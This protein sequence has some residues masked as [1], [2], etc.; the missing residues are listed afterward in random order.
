MD[1]EKFTNQARQVFA[2]SQQ[3]LQRYKHNQLDIEHILLAFL[4]QEGGIV[5]RI[6]EEAKVNRR[7]VIG[8]IERELAS[9]P[10]A[11]QPPV[12]DQQQVYITP[13]TQRVL[14][15]A[16]T[17]AERFGDT[18]V[19][20]EHI[21]LAILEDGQ[22]AAARLLVQAGMTEEDALKALQAIRGDHRV[23]DEAAESKYEALAKYSRDLTELA[24]EG[25]LDPVI[26]RDREIRRVIQ[27][28]SRRTKNNP[29][30]IGEAGV[31]KTAI[32]EGLASA[33][34]EGTVPS[35]LEGKRVL[36]LDLGGMI[37]GSKYR[38]EFE[39]RLK[40]VMD[41]IREAQGEIIVF[42][43]ELHTVV[44]A[45]AAEG[46]MDASNM[47]KPALA[48]GE[49][50][51]IGAT[52]LDE[53]RKNIEK[54]PALERR[55]QPIVVDEP[56]VEDTIEILKGLRSRYE[57]HH[58]VKITD[59]ALEAAAKLSE[60]Y[61]PDRNLP[62]KAIDVIDEAGARLRIDIFDLPA[63]P[64]KLREDIAALTEKGAEA[65]QDGRYDEAAETKQK[66]D[67]LQEKLPAAEQ[68]WAD[69]GDIDDTV[70]AEDVA[71]IIS[72]WT[73]IPALK[74][75]EEEANK[76]LD[77]EQRL[78][79]RVKGQDEAIVAVSEAIRRA[80][81][82]LKDP[83]RPI[84]SF[85][86][87]GPTGVGKTEL[88]KALAEFLFE[89][90][91]AL[92]RID[93]SEYMEKHS[94][95]RLIGAPPGYVGYEEGGQLTEA[96]RRRPYRVILLDEIE[97]AHPDVFNILLQVLED[98]RLTD[99]TGR[100]A[101]FKNT[102]IIMTSNIGSEHIRPVST[103]GTIGFRLEDKKKDTIRA[104]SEEER[105]RQYEQMRLRVTQ[106]LEDAFRP[107]LL[108][109]IDEI[110]VFHA[111]TEEEILQIVDLMLQRVQ[112][113]LA[114]RNIKLFVTQAAKELL[115]HRGYDP[116]YGARPLRREIQKQVE[117]R[118]AS[119]LLRG[120]FNDGD[121][122]QVDGQDNEIKLSLMLVPQ[123]P[124]TA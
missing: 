46:A 37:A 86:F 56:S 58:G 61:I 82:G 18:F 69:R 98:G 74:M 19:A 48:R 122:V 96:V 51:A 8:S 120:E 76:L 91:N 75:F 107:E 112:Q 84:G 72:D 121:T 83:R 2:E 31:G 66:I 13:H 1:F 92:V 20:G 64:E 124:V 68:A 87:L 38:G 32:V 14:T 63:K 57:E 40:A 15:L 44:G 36:A 80:R 90:E 43:D 81:A 77:M 94:V 11:P 109:R 42:I 33:I 117:N 59:E 118:I 73:G 6:L 34:V 88:A 17:I 111:L 95:S 5:P 71:A 119:S 21:F 50:Q 70:D 78:H 30:L 9:R 60:R 114:D 7:A 47:L 62:D 55:F 106:A 67:E 97:K 16:N 12:G 99:N 102:V 4:E 45:G 123:E 103:G 93:M 113:A 53:Y 85:I 100:V 110:I 28:L 65:A 108:N 101:D 27:V 41:E 54:D 79:E 26:G 29:V 115:A 89:D 52:T 10:Q 105:G 25:K 35:I 39:E 23:L 49:L 116:V 24:R 22:T 104:R 3:I